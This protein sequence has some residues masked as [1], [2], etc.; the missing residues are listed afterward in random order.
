MVSSTS[1]STLLSSEVFFRTVASNEIM[2]KSLAQYASNS[3]LK[4]M[5]IFYNP[6]SSYSNSMQNSFTSEFQKLGGQI[7][8]TIDLSNSSFSPKEEIEALQNQVDAIA[9]FPNKDLISTAVSIARANSELDPKNRMLIL[10]G[11]T[12]YNPMTITG[13][14]NAVEG[15]TIV[16]PWFAQTPYAKRAEQRWL[17]QVNWRT[18][19]SYDATLAV[20]SALSDNP[21]RE[22]ILQNLQSVNL[23]SSETSGEIL[24][25][26]SQRERFGEPILVQIS[27]SRGGPADSP[28]AFKPIQ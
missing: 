16:V 12:M 23:A 20:I 19:T 1:T 10:A 26:T 8:Q 7:V 4:Q 15:L 28:F 17:G 21:S 11:D 22:S 25:F 9:I 6:Q 5:A 18:A 27:R 24:K 2:G 14:G 13:G 3:G